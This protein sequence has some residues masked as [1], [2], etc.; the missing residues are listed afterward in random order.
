MNGRPRKTEAELKLSGSFQ[1]SRHANRLESSPVTE[2]PLAPSDFDKEHADYWDETCG[3]LKMNGLL[4][5][6]DPHAVREYVVL[7]MLQKK[8]FAAIQAEGVVLH[9]DNGRGETVKAN[10]ATET[11]TKLSG[12]RLS[13]MDRFGFNPKARQALKTEQ[14]APEKSEFEKLFEASQQPYIPPGKRKN[15]EA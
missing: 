1:K 15:A 13:Y 4:T 10:P 14:S 11:Y 2:I 5:K 12:L 7:S 8:A 3:L 6:T 9:I